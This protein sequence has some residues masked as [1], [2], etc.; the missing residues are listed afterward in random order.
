MSKPVTYAFIDGENLYL[1]IKNSVVRRGK[2]VYAGGGLDYKKFRDYLRTRYGVKVAYIF[3]GNIPANKD[4]YFYLQSCGFELIMKEVAYYWNSKEKKYVVKGNVDTDVVL[5][6][7]GKLYDKFT[8]AVFVS[9]D[10]DYVS[11]YDYMAEE[12]KLK[13]V[14]APNPY[15]Y[16]KLLGGH[17]GIL[18]FV[19]NN[20]TLMRTK[21]PGVAVGVKALGMPGHGDRAIVA[22]SRKKVKWGRRK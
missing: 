9:G 3:L 6:A 10:G 5:Y 2:V 20:K 13:A 19:S 16:S 12:G 1:G 15:N 22:K 11:T 21:R 17:H 4:L 18:H 14:L 7:V 8:D